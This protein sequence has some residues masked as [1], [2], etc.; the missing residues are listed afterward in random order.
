MWFTDTSK[1][2]QEFAIAYYPVNVKSVMTA[3]LQ[4]LVLSYCKGDEW[5]ENGALVFPLNLCLLTCYTFRL[6]RNCIQGTKDS[7]S[8]KQCHM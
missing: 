2:L 8:Q 1:L 4:G 3:G 7:T 6:S 5:N